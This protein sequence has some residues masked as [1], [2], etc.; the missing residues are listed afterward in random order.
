MDASFIFRQ[1]LGSVIPRPPQHSFYPKP[2]IPVP[3]PVPIPGPVPHPRDDADGD[4]NRTAHT[5]TACCRCRQRKTRCDPTLP[6][7]SP[8]ERS[9]STCE[10]FDTTKGKKINRFYVVK[11]QETVRQLEATLKQYTDDKDN[12]TEDAAQP[13]GLVRL[14]STDETPRYLGPSSGIAMTRLLIQEA[15]RYTD[16]KRIG[17]L[18]PDI[19]K[20]RRDRQDR[21][22]SMASMAGSVSGPSGGK[23]NYPMV[24]EHPAEALPSKGLRERLLEIYNQRGS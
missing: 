23:Q 17:D 24:A 7:C 21:M 16:S 5:L 11:L 2:R 13:G 12:D 1:G 10:Y 3:V 6:R 20:R 4:G 22:M 18:V 9:G 15:K 19:L 14:R 8:C